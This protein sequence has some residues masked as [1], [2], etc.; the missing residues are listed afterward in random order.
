M[1]IAILDA[2]TF[3]FEDD[4]PWA[5]LKDMGELTIYQHTPHGEADLIVE[6]CQGCEIVLT[7]KVPLSAETLKQL[8]DL[9][10][11][12]VLATGH[13]IVDGQAARKQGVVVC[14]APS[15]STQSVAQ[16]TLA[17]ILELCNHVGLHTHSV[18]DGD[19][20]RSEAFCYWKKP[21]VELS[22]ATVGFV[23][24]GEIGSRVGELVRAL[25]ANIISHTRSRRGAP[26]WADGFRWGELDEVFA[27]SDVITLHCPLTPENT[28]LVNAERLQAM[29]KTAY[30]VNTARG[31]LIDEAALAEALRNGEIAGAALDVVSS[32][33]MK[34]DNPLLGAPNCC[35]TPHVA[36]SSLPAR[37]KLLEITFDNVCA[38]LAGQPRNVVN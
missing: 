21:L 11:V 30:L 3:Y 37:T 38:H 25:G 35:I 8:P 1:K 14:N 5:P 24:W 9:K 22:G 27:E 20:V 34:A 17:L 26:D 7:N 18:H 6:R 31:P 16:H 29:K 12:G 33:P 15:Y 19:W 32:E 36:W 10:M 2:G 13:N 4:T 23:G 28:G